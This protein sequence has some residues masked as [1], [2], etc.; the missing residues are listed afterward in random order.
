[1]I[2]ESKSQVNKAIYQCGLGFYFL[3][4]HILVILETCKGYSL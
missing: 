2:L 1:M 3:D 4:A